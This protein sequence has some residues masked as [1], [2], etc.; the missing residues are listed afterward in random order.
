MVGMS[1]WENKDT[2]EAFRMLIPQN[3]REGLVGHVKLMGRV[4]LNRLNFFEKLINK[5]VAGGEGNDK[6]DRKQLGTVLEKIK[7]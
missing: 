4:D 6:V 5:M 7:E 1:P 3:I 2:Q